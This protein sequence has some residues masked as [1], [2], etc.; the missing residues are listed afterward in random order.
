MTNWECPS[1]PTCIQ[2][3]GCASLSPVVERSAT[4]SLETSLYCP[5]SPIHKTKRETAKTSGTDMDAR[6]RIHTHCLPKRGFKDSTLC[7][8]R[9]EREVSPQ[10]RKR[11]EE[12]S[13]SKP[14]AKDISS[15]HKTDTR[16]SSGHTDIS[17]TQSRLY[18]FQPQPCLCCLNLFP[19][20]PK[21]LE[22]YMHTCQKRS[23]CSWSI[24]CFFP[25]GNNGKISL[26]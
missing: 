5:C 6:H 9:H 13:S 12:E 25:D 21:Y 1:S 3:S 10:M 11:W 23:F 8:R 19:S 4:R 20:K 15:H 18:P 26:I 7:P 22:R 2:L 17:H 24:R 16:V 14:S